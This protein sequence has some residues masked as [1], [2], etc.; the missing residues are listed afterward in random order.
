MYSSYTVV[1][2]SARTVEP[3]FLVLNPDS[4]TSVL[5]DLGQ[6]AYI[7]SCFHFTGLSVSNQMTQNT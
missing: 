7:H 3:D 4:A 5:D 6:G 2:R 1:Y